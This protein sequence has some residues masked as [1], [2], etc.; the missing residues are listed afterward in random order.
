MPT[1]RR[2]PGAAAEGEALLLWDRNAAVG[3]AVFSRRKG[4]IELLTAHPQY[5][6]RGVTRALLRFVAEKELPGRPLRIT[7]FRAGDPADTGQWEDYRRLG[8]VDAGPGVQFG[9]PVQQMVL[10]FRGGAL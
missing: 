6:R 8:F 4:Y 3:A 7:T 2:W 10:P 9:Y 5:R 1:G